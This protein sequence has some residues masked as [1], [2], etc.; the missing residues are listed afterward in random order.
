MIEKT[1][2]KWFKNVCRTLIIDYKKLLL[3]LDVLI[4][5]LLYCS[6]LRIQCDRSRRD[7]IFGI[8]IIPNGHIFINFWSK[9]LLTFLV[10]LAFL[11][12]LTNFWADALF[13][14]LTNFLEN[15]FVF[16]E[17]FF[18]LVPGQHSVINVYFRIRFF[19]Y[20]WPGTTKRKIYLL[21]T[22][23]SFFFSF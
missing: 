6:I 11:F 22:H 8:K 19:S 15:L 20:Y 3:F 18:L 21:G 12:C 17:F 2:K 7:V 23:S 1:W 4:S 16:F 5:L 13:L 14:F 10:T 9:K